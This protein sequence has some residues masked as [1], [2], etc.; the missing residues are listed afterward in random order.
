MRVAEQ[1]CALVLLKDSSS[2]R[3]H[4]RRRSRWDGMA[5]ERSTFPRRPRWFNTFFHAFDHTPALLHFLKRLQQVAP[6][7]APSSAGIAFHGLPVRRTKMIPTRQFRSGIGGRP[8]FGLARCSGRRDSISLHN[9]SGTHCRA[10]PCASERSASPSWAATR[11]V[12]PESRPPSL[13]LVES[14][15]LRGPPGR[16]LSSK[17]R[18]LYSPRIVKRVL[19]QDAN[20]E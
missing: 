15:R 1:F 4:G 12:R 7:P 6:L 17:R 13:V 8:P 11:G 14:A 20:H 16:S 19:I 18:T 2:S 10:I 3:R 9:S 5:W